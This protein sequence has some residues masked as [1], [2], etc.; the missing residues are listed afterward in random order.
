MRVGPCFIG[1]GACP[2][3]DWGTRSQGRAVEA[4]HK[5][6]ENVRGGCSMK[7]KDSEVDIGVQAEGQKSKAPSY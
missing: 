5:G 1:K 3:E 2:L 4:E 7:N 6:K